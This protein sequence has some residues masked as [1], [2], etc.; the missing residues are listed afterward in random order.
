MIEALSYGRMATDFL[1]LAP[2][3]EQSAAEKALFEHYQD[4]RQTAAAASN[5]CHLSDEPRSHGRF[6]MTGTGDTNLYAY[7]AE[8]ATALV[9]KNGAVG[10]VVPAGMIT[11]DAT[12][13]FSQTVFNGRVASA[14]HFNNTEKLFPIHSSYSFVLLTLRPSEKADCVFYATRLEHLDDKRRHVTFEP[15]DLKRFNP[16]TQT[17]VL[18][19][20][21]A[22]VEI[23][24][25]LYQAAPVLV[26]ENE[27][28]GNPW[29]IRTMSMFHMSNDSDLFHTAKDS[30]DLVPLY[31]GKLFHQFDNRW[32][33]FDGAKNSKGELVE[34]DVTQEEKADP[35]FAITP[36]YWVLKS[37]VQ[38]RYV[39][40][41]GRRWW[42]EPWLLAARSVSSPTNQRTLIVSVLSANYGVGHSA[43]CLYPNVMPDLAACLLATLNSLVCDYV[44]R[45]KQSGMN[46]SLF[47]LKQIPILIP[48]QFDAYARDF[49]VPRVAALTRTSDD[50]CAVWLKNYPCY[51]YQSPEERCWIRAELDAYIARLYHLTRRDLEYILSPVSVMGGEFPTETFPGLQ[52]DETV[53]YG[54]F[55]TKR[56]VLEAYDKLEAGELK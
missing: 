35:G 46:L 17:C 42:S 52:R 19:R 14:Y 27:P 48:N 2:S 25:K 53:L 51:R 16:N 56:F 41:Q 13:A 23:C 26:N 34:R 20:T 54:E 24:R 8:L 36:R 39:D 15:G 31:E 49:I 22:D 44:I 33:T 32:A 12:K 18:V 1:G 6:P 50:L 10:L 47:L 55:L 37:D 29:G 40:R 4:A 45:I 9:R 3:E 38:E 5:F 28:D 7:F 11:D 43:N 30:D 21:E